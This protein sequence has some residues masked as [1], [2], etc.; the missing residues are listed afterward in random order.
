MQ[1]WVFVFFGGSTSQ[2]SKVLENFSGEK[3]KIS[4]QQ[5]GSEC[6]CVCARVCMRENAS[7][8]V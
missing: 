6:V 8:S 7:V 5:M 4:L 1:L 3:V 2:R